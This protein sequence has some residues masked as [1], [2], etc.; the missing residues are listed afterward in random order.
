N[1]RDDSPVRPVEEWEPAKSIGNSTT[2]PQDLRSDEEVQ[3]CFQALAASVGRR[4]RAAGVKCGTVEIALRSET[5]VWSSH[6]MRLLRP[7]DST[8]ELLATAM[9]LFHQS[10][11]WPAPLHSLGL[12]VSELTSAQAPEQ[13]DL[14][15]DYGQL[16]QERQLDRAIDS[17]QG[18]YGSTSLRRGLA[19]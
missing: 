2:T 18:K 12:R 8:R 4:L 11:R 17:I 9:E 1:G 14:F 19:I 10:H 5:L 6:R 3:R 15:T 16:Q 7:T 13:M